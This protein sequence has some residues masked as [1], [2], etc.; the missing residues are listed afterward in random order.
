MAMVEEA[1]KCEIGFGNTRSRNS[2]YV[3]SVSG[4]W[5]DKIRPSMTYACPTADIIYK[6]ALLPAIKVLFVLLPP[7]RVSAA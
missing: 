7:K 3:Y 1:S 4:M 6:S 5:S 2:V